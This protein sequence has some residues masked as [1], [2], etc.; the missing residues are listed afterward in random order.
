MPEGF[1]I[2]LYEPSTSWTRLTKT[3]IIYFTLFGVPLAPIFLAW[4][5]PGA[6]RP[7][8]PKRSIVVLC[9]LVA[10]NPL[11]FFFERHIYGEL[12]ARM[13][14]YTE[15]WTA[16][17]IFRHLDSLLLIGLAA[18]ALLRRHTLRPL[19]KILFH[20]TLFVCALWA[21]GPPLL[22]FAFYGLSS[23]QASVCRT[24]LSTG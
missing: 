6:G 22:D 11:R 23:F 14:I 3:A 4:A 16:G 20:W 24:F 7:G 13:V 5:L 1:L 12:V 2:Y 21:A 9:L 17:L 8:L 10:Y 19:P 18:T 15:A